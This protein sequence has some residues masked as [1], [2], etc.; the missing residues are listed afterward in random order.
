MG[1]PSQSLNIVN[2]VMPILNQSW[3]RCHWNSSTHHVKFLSIRILNNSSGFRNKNSSSC[4]IPNMNS[5]KK[6]FMNSF[7]FLS[8]WI[9]SNTSCTIWTLIYVF[10]IDYNFVGKQDKL[11]A[12]SLII[13]TLWLI[14]CNLKIS[15]FHSSSIL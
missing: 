4:K 13:I 6:N 2:F 14:S 8:Y 7:L 5:W 9:L 1:I 12:L 10:S 3:S 11:L 15:Y